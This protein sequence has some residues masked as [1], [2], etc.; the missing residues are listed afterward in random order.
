MTSASAANHGRQRARERQCTSRSATHP[1]AAPAIEKAAATLEAKDKELH[2]EVVSAL[3][4]IKAQSEAQNKLD[5]EPFDIWELY[6]EQADPP[7]DVLDEEERQ[8][9]LAHPVA[10]IRAV[11][12]RSFFNQQLTPE[13]RKAVPADV[14][15]ILDRF[16]DQ[17]DSVKGNGPNSRRTVRIIEAGN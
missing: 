17:I 7:V 12:A 15:A 13:Q 10:S 6:P 9:L 2:Q 8:E 14:L 16:K 3:T 5:R 1:A 4:A 11:A